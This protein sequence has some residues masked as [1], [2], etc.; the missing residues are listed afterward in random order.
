MADLRIS[1]LPPLASADA[2]ANDDL[3][4][5]DYSASE[6]KRLTLK[7]AVQKAV[8]LIDDGVIPGAKLVTDSVTATQIAANAVTASELA[9]DAVDT[10]AIQDLAVT[11]AKLAGSIDGAK[12][13]ADS[14]TAREIAPNAVTAS[15]LADDAVD[16]TAIQDA[17]VTNVKLATGIDG[18]K[19]VADSVT[20]AQIAPDAITASELASDAVDTAAVQDAAITNVKLASGIDGGKLVTDSVTAT[21]IAPDAITA[22]EL[23]DGAVDT[24]AVQDAAITDVKLASGIDGAKLIADSVTAT[25]IAADAITASELADNA[26]DTAAVQDS[27]IT[28]AKLAS[29]IDGAKLTDDTV[30]AAKIPA[31]SL[32]RGLDKTTGA[33]GHTNSIT[34]GA[35]AGISF[36]SEGH[37]TGTTPLVSA[38]LPIATATAIGGVSIPTNS[39]LSVSGTGAVTHGTT[40]TAGSV[41]GITFSETGHITATRAIEGGDLP[42]ATASVKGAVSVPG[43]ALQVSAAGAITHVDSGVGAGTYT[44]V[45][46]N[47]QG[48]VTVGAP[49][50]AGDIP[51]LDASKVNTGTFDA[52]RIADRS[53]TNAKLAN[54]ATTL[55]QEADPGVSDHY[56]GQFWYRESDAQLRTWSG[57]SWIPVGFGRLSQENLRF[58]GTF[59]AATGNVVIPTAFGTSAG[60]TAGAAI[61]AATDPLT[62]AYLVCSTPGTYNGEVYDNGDWTLCLG[63]SQGWSRVDTLSGTAGST[64]LQDLLDVT[65]TTAQAGDTLIFDATTSQWVNRPTAAQKATFTT[66][67]D[68]T[69]TTFTMS[70]DGSSVNNLIIS[71]GGII[72]EPGIDFNFVAPR[73]VNFTTPPPAGID[74]WILIEGVQGGGGGGGGTTLPDGTAAEEFLGWNNALSSWVARTTLVGGTY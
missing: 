55:I 43:P 39:G 26:V 60:M 11:N 46:V 17:A 62:G 47:G 24:A 7:G 3:A 56:V 42:A 51:S 71:L 13:V 32:D 15:E 74:S 45:T 64:R 1:E 36:D 58:C 19:L 5:A 4:I 49:L 69:T 22:S 48:H 67:P 38:D 29:G 35:S 57:N 50:A 53:V 41:S 9:D 61:P 68:G 34:A 65:I 52:A 20:A 28:D 44:K 2:E 23:A 66:A 59:D 8:T 30:T 40:I 37:V 18:A 25:Q 10:A 12:L 27:A 72:Q 70:R 16:T 21:Q 31:A 6:T 73:T 33:I 63:Q 14:V 54:Q